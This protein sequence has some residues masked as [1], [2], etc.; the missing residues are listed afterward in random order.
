MPAVPSDTLSK[1]WRALDRNLD[2]DDPVVRH[3]AIAEVRKL[4]PPPRPEP[5]LVRA[6][7]GTLES[8]ALEVGQAVGAGECGPEEGAAVLAA[9]KLARDTA[10]AERGGG[11]LFP[12]SITVQTPGVD[13]AAQAL[14]EA[15]LPDAYH[16]HRA[17]R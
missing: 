10:E 15:G 4:L 5:G 8:M 16:R 7:K 2:D 17:G 14:A 11:A 9:M 12:F 13:S 3:S 1:F 6:T